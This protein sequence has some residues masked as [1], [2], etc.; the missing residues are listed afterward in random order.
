MPQ[1]TTKGHGFGTAPVFL[2][3]ISTILGA[4]MFLRFGYAVGHTG[5]MGTVILIFIG[6]AITIPTALAIAEIATNLKVEGG[7][8]YFIISRS[9]GARI[10][11]A[12]GITLY[13]S[14]AISVAFYMIAFSQ[15]FTPL[16]GWFKDVTG[17][18]PDA[19]MVSAPFTIL[20]LLL[21]LK[22]G[23]NLGVTALWIVVSILGISLAAFF[24]GHPAEDVNGFEFY[25][26]IAEPDKFSKVFAI[27]FPAFT[28]M[29]AGVGLSGD[30]RNP[31]K[32]IPL[33]TLS[34]TIIG[35]FVYIIIVLKLSVSASPETLVA[36]QLIMSKIAVWGPIIPIGLAAATISS[37]IGSVLI[38]PRTLQA[39]SVDNIWPVKKINQ[40]LK[41]SK[42]ESNE[43]V[44][45]TLVTAV[46]VMVFVLL[47]DVDFVAQII[48]MFFLITYGTLCLV[49]FLEHFAGSPSY[50]PTFRSKWALSLIGAV[51]S[52]Y[53]MFQI[54]PLYAF[55][56]LVVMVLIYFGL[57]KVRE[58]ETDLTD[59]FKGVLFKI[60][61]QLQMLIQRN[62]N[63]STQDTWRPAFIA[64]SSSTAYRIAHYDFLRWIAHYYGF[65]TY[66]HFIKGP[67]TEDNAQNARQLLNKIIHQ[68]MAA[69]ASIYADTIISPSFTTAVAQ[70]IQAP[71]IFGM[72]NN[73]ILFEF[74]LSD[75]EELI[76]IIDGC[77]FSATLGYSICV[78]RSSERHFGYKKSLHIWLT[79]GDYSNANL[80]IL[81]AYILMGT[82]DWKGCHIS[83]FAAFNEEDMTKEVN[84]L[85]TLI[86]KGR[87]PISRKNVQKMP[88]KKGMKAFEALVNGHSQDADLV[89]TGFSVSKLA[90]DKGAFF[91]SFENIPDILFVRAGQRISIEE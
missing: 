13:L 34:A 69:E 20:L 79:P 4:I 75:K 19:R 1:K 89:I 45:A 74:R 37:A 59:V 61:R 88:F 86:D 82:P 48:S 51:A 41:K 62:R 16:F 63:G 24:F 21:I 35:M 40:F 60:T 14:Q 44:N 68:G 87:I 39:L 84:R 3:A 50:R 29:T 64:L 73:S 65:G 9:F 90:Q 78:L 72:E 47:G 27:I 77:S 10:G 58:D 56:A 81:L 18:T 38:A 12:I 83:I 71:G 42:G 49:S 23:A 2:A 57:K 11:G 15:A 22:K 7:G 67:L 25:R 17:I 5:A 32:S 53:M 91:K 30:L 46:I 52:F 66:F 8:E 54:E 43:P 36:D 55:L 80:M 85:N 33:G 26:H 31:R 70:I 76:N 6:H 28:G